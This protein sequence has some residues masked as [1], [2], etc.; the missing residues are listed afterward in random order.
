MC[1]MGNCTSRVIYVRKS[2]SVRIWCLQRSRWPPPRQEQRMPP[3]QEQSQPP[4][5][6]VLDE[7]HWHHINVKVAS[8]VFSLLASVEGTTACLE[9]PLPSPPPPGDRH[10]AT[11]SPPP[12]PPGRPSRANPGVC[13]GGTGYKNKLKCRA[14]QDPLQV[15]SSD[16]RKPLRFRLP[17]VEGIRGNVSAPGIFCDP[18]PTGGL[19]PLICWATLYGFA[20]WPPGHQQ[21]F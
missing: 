21:M 1:L 20:P 14:I 9:I 3:S 6:L 2:G 4:N 11:V 10:L 16:P 17:A 8:H 19:L 18:C 5:G 12:P 15:N 13:K 7:T